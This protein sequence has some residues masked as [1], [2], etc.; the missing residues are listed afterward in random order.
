MY[1][2]SM[3]GSLIATIS[4]SARFT[5][6]RKTRR[7]I[8]PKPLIP[9]FFT[10]LLSYPFHLPGTSPPPSKELLPLAPF[11]MQL[12]EGPGQRG[13]D[14]RYFLIGKL[15]AQTCFGAAACFLRFSLVDAVGRNGE[16]RQDGDAPRRNFDE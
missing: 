8:R 1:S 14:G 10:M 9:I 11:Y 13:V 4:I 2:A 5:A 15:L 3:N 7:P 16:I 12:R 6:A